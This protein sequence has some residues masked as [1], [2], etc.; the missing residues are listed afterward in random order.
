[1]GGYLLG[2]DAGTGSVRALLV[3]VETGK[4]FSSHRLWQHPPSPEGGWAWDFEADENWALLARTVAEVIQKADISPTDVLG[5]AVTS[6]RHTLVLVRNGRVLLAVPNLDARAAAE[7]TDLAA[8]KGENF[9]SRTGRWPLPIFLASRLQWLARH[10]PDWLQGS[11][12]LTISDWVAYRLCGEIATDFSNAGESML[13]DL[14]R[15]EWAADLLEELGLPLSVLPPVVPSG[16][17]LGKLT[18]SVAGELGLVPGIPV[19]VGGAD[20]QCALLGMGTITPGEIGIVAGTTAPIQGIIDRPLLDPDGRLWTGLHVLP[21]RWVLESNAGQLGRAL[22]WFARVLFPDSPFAHVRL[23]AEAS[24]ASPGAG[25]LCSTF[26]AHVF[27]AR[28][29]A[30]PAGSLT[31]CHFTGEGKSVRPLVCRA[32]LEGMA[33]ALR[34]NLE[35]ISRVMGAP[36]SVSMSGG[37]TRS[38]FWT[39]LV[40][41]VLGV[42]VYRS[43]TP[44]SAALGAAICAG[45]GAGVFSSLIDGISRLVHTALVRPN[46]GTA[47]FYSSL[48]SEW[49]KLCE[50]QCEFRDH[51]ANRI[52]QTIMGM[53]PPSRPRRAQFRPKI[54]VTAQMDEESLN[55]LRLLGDV[56]YA[57]Y[58]DSLRVLTGDE[59]VEAL[60]GVHVFITEVDVVDLDALQRLPELRV[61]VSCRGRA[62]NV[63]L[64]ACTALGIPVLY[65]P[66]RNAHAVADLTVAFMIALLRRLILADRFLRQPGGEAGDMARMGQAHELFL[67]RELWGK[68]VGLVGF[69]AIGREVARRLVPFGVRLLV[70]DPYIGPEDAAL[71]DA[72]LVS[73]ERLLAESDIISLHAAVTPET[74][75]MIGRE[76][77]ARMKRGAFLINTARAA[78]VDEKALVE[79]L[80]SGHLAGAAVDV[81]SVEP[82]A[83][84]DP[85]LLMPNV[86]A[87]PH[88][89]GNT[90]EVAIH[91]GRMVVEDLDRLLRGERPLHI[92]NP[93]T[94]ESFSWTG[95]RRPIDEKLLRERAERPGP[96]V[97]DL[98]QEQQ[99]LREE[100]SLMKE[101]TGPQDIRARMERILHRFCELVKEDPKV[102]HFAARQRVMSHYVVTDLGLEFHIGFR[103]GRVI[104]GLGAP[105]EPAEVRMKASAETLDG[106]FSGRLSGT[107]AA[108]SGKLAFSGDVR[109]AMGMQRLQ[110]DLVRLY[111]QAREEMGGVDFAGAAPTPVVPAPAPVREDLREEIVQAVSE[112]YQLG[113]ITATGGNVSVRIEGREE[114][115]ITPSQLHKGTLRPEHIVRITFEGQALEPGALAPSSE[116]PMH[117]AIYRAQPEA[118]AIVHAHAP[119]A[120][121]LALSRLPFL[122]VTTEAAF[123]KE[124]PVVPFIMPGTKELAQAVVK[125]MERSPVCLLQNHGVVVAASSLRQ[126]CNLVEIVERAAHLIVSCY[127][128]GRKPVT[129]PRDV[130]RTLQNLGKMMA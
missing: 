119:Y 105:P 69:G 97:S 35:Q 118:Q 9:Y 13:F 66:G 100:E 79:A 41:D 12:A 113:L 18:A 95:P 36:S 2:I 33:F 15:R 121:I 38:S 50:L 114:C 53:E 51:A 52:V 89:G 56:E 34:A 75:G 6:M 54:L 108:M 31:L 127:M 107:K 4:I 46:K 120:T 17:F 112:L 20:T 21:G 49:Q 8:E 37:M 74:R 117:T 110:G 85:L 111:N 57:C 103:E 65:A 67:G 73:L 62:V 45:A 61:I 14:H 101:A 44:E 82:P 130:V 88:I 60:Q 76:E 77:L 83:S 124:V 91:Q 25:G 125:A 84:D 19:A 99:I 59:L 55:Q 22:E 23:L 39:Q 64:D 28:A 32:V 48:Y 106:I 98:Q 10:H 47:E 7:S 109:L 42:P 87:T 30:F 96:A 3:D 93:Q 116:W 68:T 70:Y 24:R 43:E 1:M 122:P 104:A 128:L 94:L 129:L 11:V 86:I 63:D 78:L 81:F 72:E 27:N 71:Y 80:Q 5:I 102:N 90:E 92:L 26:G 126:A 16:T 58:R 123:L 29:M 115:W 40:A